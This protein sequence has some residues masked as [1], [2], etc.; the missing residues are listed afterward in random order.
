MDFDSEKKSLP[1]DPGFF[2]HAQKPIEAC[3]VWEGK[4]LEGSTKISFPFQQL[5]DHSNRMDSKKAVALG[6]VDFLNT[7]IRDG[8]IATDDKESVDVASK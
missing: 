2:C 7:C 3:G 8:T 6:I 5:L 4:S 1:W